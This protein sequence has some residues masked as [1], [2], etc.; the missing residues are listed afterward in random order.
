MN[1]LKKY[2]DKENRFIEMF[3]ME[4]GF[5]IRSGIIDEEGN[6]TGADPFMRNF[7]QLID[8]GVMGKCIHGESGLCIK[9]GIECYQDGLNVKKENMPLDNF[10]KIIGQSKGKVFQV[11]LGGRGDVNKHEQFEEILKCC[12]DN[13][14]VPNF[15][16]SG[17]SLTQEEVD[18]T[19]K[20][21]GAVAV[22]E[23]RSE[24]TRKAIK[25]F[26][27]ADVKTNIHYVLGKNTIDEA[28]KKLS[29]NGF[30]EGIN[31]VIFL[32]HKPIG[33]GSQTNV[34]DAEDPRVKE[35]FSLVDNGK[36]DFKIGFDSCSCAGV[37]NFTKNVNSDSMDY[38]E[39]ARYSCYI[40]ADMNL[41]PCSFG[42]QNPKYFVDLNKY[43]IL[44]G[45][46]SEI[47]NKF[48][49]SL[50]FSCSKCSDR[51]IC[52]MCP[53]VPQITLCNRKEKDFY[54]N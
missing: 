27:D 40:D 10:K 3:N 30:D 7:P 51:L 14:I 17:L 16:T 54:E 6:D 46:N 20:Y 35:F 44:E 22:S 15:T 28:I 18:I 21:C 49:N 37:V 53:I 2:I 24:Y 42:N 39:A 31:A 5:Y 11:A 8:I 50:K 41:M 33:L 9:S 29:S 25:M 34:L 23:Y 48:R 45:W 36:Y 13:E 47:F 4:T 1:T 32:M 43:T 38:C 19:K 12:R 26:I 52:G